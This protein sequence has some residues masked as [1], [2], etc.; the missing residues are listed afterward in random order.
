MGRIAGDAG[1]GA[2]GAGEGVKEGSGF[3]IKG[4]GLRLNSRQP[5]NQLSGKNINA[6]DSWPASL[7]TRSAGV[8][9][10]IKAVQS[11][12]M[13]LFINHGIESKGECVFK[14]FGIYLLIV[15]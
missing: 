5:R 12:I 10:G 15:D 8:P 3:K 13:Q 7:G 4:P 11:Q 2:E 14:T 6:P 9:A 1:Q